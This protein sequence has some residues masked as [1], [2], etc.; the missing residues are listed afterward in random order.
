MTVKKRI[1]I[2]RLHPHFNQ[3]VRRYMDIH[4]LTQQDLADR[5]G[6]ERSH[7]NG[8]IND[9]RALTTYYVW[10]FLRGGVMLTSDI[11]DGRAQSK[12]EEEFWQ[13]AKEAENLSNLR[14]I[15]ELRKRGANV[16]ELLDNLLSCYPSVDDK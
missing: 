12:V 6:L 1:D 11:Y 15:G 8:L 16:G 7:V 2:E 9:K 3:L 5:I 13:T 4:D 10:A 14:K